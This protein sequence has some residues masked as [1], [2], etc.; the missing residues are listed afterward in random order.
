MRTRARVQAQGQARG[1]VLEQRV[2]DRT[3][4]RDPEFKRARVCMWRRM[5]DHNGDDIPRDPGKGPR[6]QR[7][8]FTKFLL[9]KRVY[10]RLRN[11][12]LVNVY[13]ILAGIM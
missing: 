10:K 4:R 3:I 1:Q 8:A 9:Y 11:S 5:A 2:W 12:N 13:E 7:S 6:P